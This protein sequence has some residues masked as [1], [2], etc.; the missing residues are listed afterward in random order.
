MKILQVNSVCGVGSTGRIA[1][2]IYK[3]L[4]E[5]GHECC[6]AYGRGTAPEGIKTIKI[7]SNIDNYIHVAKTRL[8]DKHGFASKRATEE[9]VKKAEEFNP[10]VIH[11]HNIHGYYLNIEILFKFLKKFNKPVIWTLHDS[12]AFTGHCAYFEYCGCEKWRTGCEKCEQKKTY[13]ISNLMDNSKWNF[14]KKKELFTSVEDLTIITPSKWLAELTKESFL[15]KYPVKVINN[16]IDLEVFKPTANNIKNENNIEDKFLVLGVASVW[17][18]RKGLQDFFKLNEVLDD[19]FKIAI[20]GVNEKQK[21]ELPSNFIGITRTNSVE[22][23]AKLYTAADVFVNPTYEDNFPTT[24]LEALAC[25]TQII[26]YNTGGSVESVND[27]CG[28]VVEK[29]EIG[30]LKAA[31]EALRIKPKASEACVKESI[32]YDKRARYNDYLQVYLAKK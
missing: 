21:L 31:I 10:D 17:E 2:D 32:K 18:E 24:N 13:P 9:F 7:G 23:L 26:T 19:S 6:I 8:L 1:T 15:A 14:T 28:I 22:E 20:V 27:N 25:G 4:E 16:G 3:V 5:Q 30:K 11:L 12:W 29:G